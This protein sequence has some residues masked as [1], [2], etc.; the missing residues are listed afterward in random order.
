MFI[1]HFACFAVLVTDNECLP[2]RIVVFWDDLI[3]LSV[4]NR[5]VPPEGALTMQRLAVVLAL[6]LGLCAGCNFDSANTDSE[7]ADQGTHAGGEEHETIE[8]GNLGGQSASGELGRF[9]STLPYFRHGR[10]QLILGLLEDPEQSWRPTF[11]LLLKLANPTT[12]NVTFTNEPDGEMQLLRRGYLTGS[13]K[14]FHIEYRY[15]DSM[16]PVKD[17]LALGGD[18]YPL[19]SGR[20]FTIDL[21]S[22]P[23]QITQLDLDIPFALPDGASV[24]TVEENTQTEHLERLRDDLAATSPQVED[25]IASD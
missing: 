9:S 17:R 12:I 23:V 19:E 11:V 3:V 15:T 14:R 10:E 24:S 4:C 1:A 25:F 7:P 18:N 13:G 20:V 2:S 8:S 5:V 22:D 21:S 16:L 6:L